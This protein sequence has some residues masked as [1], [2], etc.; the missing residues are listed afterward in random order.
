M[1]L[2]VKGMQMGT[3]K[4]AKD[5]LDGGRHGEQGLGVKLVLDDGVPE[6]GWDRA[7]GE[8]AEERQAGA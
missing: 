5:S 3:K 7:L 4:G 1:G 2:E 6:C 8:M